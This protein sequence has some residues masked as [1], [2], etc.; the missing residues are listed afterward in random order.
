MRPDLT[1]DHHGRTLL[2]IDAKWKRLPKM[3]RPD[4]YERIIGL[5]HDAG[6]RG[7][8][9]GLSGKKMECTRISLRSH[10]VAIDAM[11]ATGRGHAPACAYAV[12]ATGQGAEH[13][14]LAATRSGAPFTFRQTIKVAANHLTRKY[15]SVMSARRSSSGCVNMFSVSRQLQLPDSRPGML[16]HPSEPRLS[17]SCSGTGAVG[18]RTPSQANQVPGD[19]AAIGKDS[20]ARNGV[21][22]PARSRTNQSSYRCR[23]CRC[24]RRCCVRN[25]AAKR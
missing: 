17:T 21:R 1:I 9:V 14:R 3:R 24:R 2:V 5:W 15:D 7:G 10:T 11:H 13:V 22:V 12:A 8:G 16:M 25:C 4:L 18:H 23:A 20:G 19:V 6:S